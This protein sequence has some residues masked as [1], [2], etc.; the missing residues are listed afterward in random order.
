MSFCG[1]S[2]HVFGCFRT[3]SLT[4]WGHILGVPTIG[5]TGRDKNRPKKKKISEAW[6]PPQFQEKRYRSERAILGA[7][8]EFRGILGA[9]L[10]IGNS[11][12]GIRN[13]ILRMASH[14]LINT[15]STILG[16]TLAAN[17]GIA[18]SPPERVSSSSAFAE[19][20]FKNWGG[21]RPP[22]YY[23][24]SDAMT[25]RRAPSGV[26]VCLVTIWGGVPRKK[27]NLSL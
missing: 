10:G 6:E 25:H 24:N 9:A 8:G 21:Y 19:R 4:Y 17:P 18:M 11:I 13:S 16:A 1:F 26:F 23:P 2:V 5:T 15:K 7:L 20:F 27:K 12:L 14:N 3:N 22:E